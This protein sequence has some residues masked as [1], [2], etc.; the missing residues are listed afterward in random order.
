MNIVNK[1]T[2]SKISLKTNQKYL[3]SKIFF[4]L[5]IL[6]LIINSVFFFFSSSMVLKHLILSVSY[7][8]MKMK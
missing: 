5:S 4:F 1:H 8:D 6:I 2:N 3:K 7:K